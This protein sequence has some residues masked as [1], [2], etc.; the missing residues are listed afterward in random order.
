M[1]I[2]LILAKVGF[3]L[4]V[5]LQPYYVLF[6]LSL[7]AGVFLFHQTLTLLKENAAFILWN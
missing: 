6:L 3:F 2:C 7:Y 4:K 5:Y 1:V